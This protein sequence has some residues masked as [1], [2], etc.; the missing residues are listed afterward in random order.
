MIRSRTRN[1][2]LALLASALMIAP[3]GAYANPLGGQVV[4][5]QATIAG[6][7]TKTVTITQ[8]SGS[9]IINWNTFN[10]GAGETAHKTIFLSNVASWSNARCRVV[11]A[12]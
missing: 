5:G 4:G 9:A 11:R 2:R 10:I 8:S 1:R 3:S 7:G 6:Q 12:E